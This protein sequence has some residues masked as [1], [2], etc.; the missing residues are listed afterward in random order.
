MVSDS[1]NKAEKFLSIASQFKLGSLITESP[2]PATRDLSSLA[3]NNLPEA[4]SILKELDRQTIGVL[5]E[6]KKQ[7]CYLK[8]IIHDTLKSGNN[9]FFC[10]CGATGRLSLTIETLWRQVYEKNNIKDRV[11]SFMA[12]GD[13]ALI[14]SIENFEDFPHYGA[15]QLLESGFKDGDLLIGTTEGGETPFVIG[16]VEKAAQ[17]SKRKP[18]FMYCNPDDI[19]CEVAERSKLVIQNPDIEKINLTVG[20]MAVTG[21]TR[22]Q[23]STILLAAAG[24]ALFYYKDSNETIEKEIDGFIRFWDSADTQF[25]EKFIVLES[26][27]YKNGDYL[28]YETDNQ[29]G[30]TVI[31]DTTE[32]S[33]TFS[34]FPFENANEAEQNLSLCYLFMPDAADSEKA[35]EKLLWRSPRTLEW[36]DINGIASRERLLGF[37][38]SSKVLSRREHQ[39]KPIRQHRFK[40]LYDQNGINF[41]LGNERYFL[42]TPFSNPL[43]THLILKM[44]LNVHSTLIMGRLGRYEGNVMT[45]VR[46]SNNKLIDRAIRYI[47]LLLKN[48]KINLPYHTLAHILFEMIEKTPS[49]QSIV[50]ATVAEIERRNK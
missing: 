34:L 28:L 30:I 8:D 16:A 2:H 29:L 48:K 37:D 17:I 23:S 27:Y 49:D 5:S 20:P 45:Y 14:R 33:P 50:L 9:I 4:I 10:G 36:P 39:Q 41:T 13:V 26:D 42:T 3:V 19:L 12:G 25:I 21:S 44:I 46:A 38:F 15:R 40:I 11:F 43:F 1:V 47:D 18:F 31:T 7:I 24:I 22:M 6:K 32:R 35:W